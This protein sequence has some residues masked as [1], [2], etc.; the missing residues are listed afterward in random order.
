[1]PPKEII[2]KKTINAL[3]CE[4]ISPNLSTETKQAILNDPSNANNI[5]FKH[6]YSEILNVAS[7][8]DITGDYGALLSHMVNCSQALKTSLL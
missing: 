1:M 8:I 5:A 6:N 2:D 7:T 3:L 4:M